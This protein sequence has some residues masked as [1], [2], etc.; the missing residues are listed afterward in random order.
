MESEIIYKNLLT[1][2]SSNE[3]ATF[4]QSISLAS[5]PRDTPRSSSRIAPISGYLTLF[6]QTVPEKSSMST[7]HL[8]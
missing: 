8:N 2:K 4:S 7:V 5:F 1:G 3:A 6:P